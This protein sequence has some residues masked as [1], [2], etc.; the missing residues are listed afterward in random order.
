M[1]LRCSVCSETFE[2]KR[3]SAKYCGGTCRN[4][5]MRGSPVPQ[6]VTDEEA[7]ADSERV[8]ALVARTT[9]EL[10]EAGVLDSVMG[11][12]ALRLAE[13]LAGNNDTG[14][15][16]ASLSKEFRAVMQQA[17]GDGTKKSDSLDELAARRLQKVS[18]A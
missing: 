16:M 14:S 15:A 1:R 12:M 5:A 10:D 7:R 13:K 2:A 8:H 17:L 9:R 4:R 18:G 6:I 11:Q 3:S